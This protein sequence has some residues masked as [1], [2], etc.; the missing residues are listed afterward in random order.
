MARKGKT[1]PAAD[2]ASVTPP[3]APLAA[4]FPD[5]VSSVD[6]HELVAVGH[7]DGGSEFVHHSQAKAVPRRTASPLSAWYESPAT[8]LPLVQARRALI[9]SAFDQGWSVN[10]VNRAHVYFQ[11]K[12]AAL[13]VVAAEDEDT[14][15]LPVTG[16]PDRVAINLYELMASHSQDLP[17]GKSVLCRARYEQSTSV[18]PALV[19]RLKDEIKV[20]WA[21]KRVR[22]SDKKKTANADSTDEALDHEDEAEA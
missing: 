1:N 14:E 18:G 11:T 22:S 20:R 13:Y 15:A 8:L 10:R 17:I 21:S 12:E 16:W 6:P 9:Q 4:P 7:V 3:I 2:A 5:P 19:V